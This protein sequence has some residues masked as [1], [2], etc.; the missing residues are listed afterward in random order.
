M[1]MSSYEARLLKQF[2]AMDLIVANLSAQSADLSN[3]LASLPG[4]VPQK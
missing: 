2:N 1:K 3:R 4:V